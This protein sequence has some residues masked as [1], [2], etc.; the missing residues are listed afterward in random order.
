MKPSL[1]PFQIILI[2][3]FIFLAFLSL[4]VLARYKG[5][6]SNAQTTYGKSVEIWGTLPSQ[7]FKNVLGNIAINNKDFSVVHYKQVDAQNFDLTFLNAIAEGKSPDMIILPSEDL[8]KERAK[9]MPIPYKTLP[10]QNFR[11]TYVDGAAIFARPD[12]IYAVPFAVDPLMMYWNRDLFASAGLANPPRTWEQLTTD[13]VP[14]LT[15]RTS[16]L[17]IV[18]SAVAFGEVTNVQHAKDLLIMLAL[19]SGSAGIKEV[20]NRYEVDLNQAI[21]Q[22]GR[23]PLEAA[24]QFFT[25]FSNVNSP[26]YSWNRAMPNDEQAFIGGKLALYFGLGSEAQDISNKNPN[27]NFDVT[28]VPQGATATVKRT[29]GTFYGFAIP[30]AAKNPSGAYAA[31]QTLMTPQNNEALTK[32]LNMASPRRDVIAA[33]DANIYRSTMLQSALIARS[34]LD[35]DPTA[36]QSIFSQMVEDVLSGRARVTQ[37][38]SDAVSRL[39]LKY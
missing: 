29:Y 11:N 17:S 34:W 23:P 26:L 2:A 35:P 4:V 38:A 37:A 24:L 30:R 8:V 15:Q 28:S 25:D 27:L 39:I 18:Q 36:S 22:G 7:V 3:I 6:G 20:N 12:G 16:S 5:G 14:K 33:G 31:I 10:L 9:L 1:R 19:Q 32:A 21:T 13:D